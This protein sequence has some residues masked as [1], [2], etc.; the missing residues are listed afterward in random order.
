MLLGVVWVPTWLPPIPWHGYMMSGFPPWL[1]SPTSRQL[2]VPSFLICR[3][4]KIT[5]IQTGRADGA[6]LSAGVTG[7]LNIAVQTRCQYRCQV[8]VPRPFQDTRNARGSASSPRL[9]ARAARPKFQEIEVDLNPGGS[10]RRALGG[11]VTTLSFPSAGPTS[12]RNYT[13]TH[14]P[15]GA[16][17]E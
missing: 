7:H 6:T 10:R 1:F 17:L 9:G 14:R 16:S 15:P 4:K 2:L 11:H 12:P 13:H 5:I 8:R 3:E